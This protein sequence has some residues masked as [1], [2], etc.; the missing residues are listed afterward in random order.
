MDNLLHQDTEEVETVLTNRNE[1]GDLLVF[2]SVT[3]DLLILFDDF[4]HA[5]QQIYR[6]DIK[7][8]FNSIQLYPSTAQVEEMLLSAHECCQN[9]DLNSL[10]FGQFAFFAS[11]LK[12]EYQERNITFA[13]KEGSLI[14]NRKHSPRTN[15]PNVQVFLGGACNPTTWRKEIA[16][17]IL[18]DH[19]ITYFNPTAELLLFVIE[20]STRGLSS[21]VEAAYVAGS[22]G[23]LILVLRELPETETTIAGETLSASE[24]EDLNRGRKFL[25]DTVERVDIPVFTDI[26]TA[27]H[28]CAKVIKVGTKITNLTTDDGAQ[29]VRLAD[30][31]VDDSFIAAKEKYDDYNSGGSG[32]LTLNEVALAYKAFSGKALSQDNVEMLSGLYESDP[33]KIR[34]SFEEFCCLLTEMLSDRMIC[35]DWLFNGGPD[36]LH[37]KDESV[38]ERDIFL[39]GSCGR[40]TWRE[41]VAIPLL[42]KQAIS[43]FNPQLPDWSMKFLGIEAE[44]KK[45]S[46]LLLYFIGNES[47]CVA[48]MVEIAYYI[49][50][51]RNVVL[52]IQNFTDGNLLDGVTVTGRSLLD[53]NRARSYLSDIA[54]RASIPVFDDITEAIMSAI[55]EIKLSSRESET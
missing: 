11:L 6:D 42:K 38:F 8:A 17:P 9:T 47:R 26:E 1:H 13:N 37:E 27:I 2:G 54:N 23:P 12:K 41:D 21:M 20:E 36:I 33:S 49:G 14:V 31:S 5:S 32:K 50:L 29:P 43:Y 4:S 7:K 18:K 28:C 55:Q 35:L 48:S 51:G 19:C 44:A 40:S 52:C 39:G 45:H 30:I 46:R 34:M 22:G 25:R 53:Y 16:I 24:K 10:T 3:R 15:H